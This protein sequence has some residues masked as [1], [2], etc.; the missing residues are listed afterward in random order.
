MMSSTRKK[1]LIGAG[2]LFV[3]GIVG[4]FLTAS[5]LSR[6]FEPYLREQALVYLQKR[7]NSDVQ[8]ASLM[9]RL[10]KASLI[11]LLTKGRGAIAR[12]EGSGIVLR[13]RQSSNYP[14]LLTI[15]HFTFD[16]D[17][18]TLWGARKTVPRVSLEGVEIQVPPRGDRPRFGDGSKESPRAPADQSD[19][20]GV[21]IEKVQIQELTLRLLP[22]DPAKVPLKFGIHHLNLQSAGAGVAMK[23]DADFTNPK[24]P[25]RIHSV[26]SFGPWSADEPGDTPLAGDYTFENAD[27]GVFNGIAGILHSKGSFQGTL[28]TVNA[29]GEASVPDFRLKSA[30]NPVPLTTKFEVQVDG[31]NGNT[32]LKPVQA[33]LG[34][35]RFTTSGGVIK[36]DEDARRR[37][38]LSVAMPAGRLNDLLRLAMKGAPLMEG[39]IHLDTKISIPPLSSKVRE[40]LLLDGHFEVTDAKFLRSKIQDQIDG[41]SR[42]GQG[43]PNNEEIDEV[44]SSMSGNFRLEN[45]RLTFRWLTFGVT[46][47]WVDLAGSYLLDGDVLDMHGSLRL[48]AKVSQT[49]SGWKRWALKPV[50]PFFA[51]NGAGTFLK[52]PGRRHVAHPEVRFG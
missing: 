52:N 40:K 35:T 50:D 26:G 10:P 7:F 19:Q 38:D 48:R 22:K 21:M 43:Q 9:V 8:L 33:T 51:K 45:E 37:I 36:H 16:A 30:G 3:L 17:L 4:A 18:G 29:H 41:L 15:R 11:R 5:L 44:V 49:Q 34:S 39:R 20:A 24:P 27:L 23:Y 31:T 13:H 2:L 12:V 47:A 1:W 25:G 14:P 42:R 46:G 6:K 32:I 28:D